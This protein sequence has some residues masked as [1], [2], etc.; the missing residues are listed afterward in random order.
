MAKKRLA[1]TLD[2]SKRRKK[3]VWSIPKLFDFVLP[4]N[5]GFIQ[6]Y[7]ATILFLKAI[8]FQIL[9]IITVI[10]HYWL[11][12]YKNVIRFGV[13]KMYRFKSSYSVPQVK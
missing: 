4:G 6:S 11:I 10:H 3:S 9:S 12:L 13:F 1:D 5:R 8:L 2:G 7:S